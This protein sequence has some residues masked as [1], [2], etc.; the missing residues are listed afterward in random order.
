MLPSLDT[1]Y[2]SQYVHRPHREQYHQRPEHHL[3]FVKDHRIQ[4]G[5][6]CI[7]AEFLAACHVKLKT[8]GIYN[9]AKKRSEDGTLV[10]EAK[11]SADKDSFFL[12]LTPNVLAKTANRN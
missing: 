11:L 9:N 10:S 8:H 7:A 4:K 2:A 5:W 12:K 1:L 6:I 3:D